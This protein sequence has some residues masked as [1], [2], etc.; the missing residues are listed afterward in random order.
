M[1]VSWNRS[2]RVVVPFTS[3]LDALERAL[4]REVQGGARPDELEGDLEQLSRDTAWFRSSNAGSLA[5]EAQERSVSAQLYDSI[6]GKAAALRALCS[7]LGGLEGQ[8]L[9]VFVSQR[10]PRFV[11]G[12]RSPLSPRWTDAKDVIDGV[13]AA[14]NANGVTIYATYP[15]SPSLLTYSVVGKTSEGNDFSQPLGSLE[16][17]MARNQAAALDILTEETG[18]RMARGPLRTLW[19]VPQI[20]EDL[21]STT[22]SASP[23]RRT[24]STGH[25]PW[26]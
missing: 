13:A 3:D 2:A 4:E 19:L 18:G 26:P 12:L 7:S 15:T 25:V 11:I 8:K 20:R 24:G 16:V 10:F 21:D 5:A 22:R 23:R 14:A 9:L 1:V 6:K 17:R